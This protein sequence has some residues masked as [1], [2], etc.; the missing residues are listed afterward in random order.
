MM[1]LLLYSLNQLITMLKGIGEEK[2]DDN[3]TYEEILAG[4]DDLE[5]TLKENLE[6]ARS[7][8]GDGNN[9]PKG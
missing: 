9:K 8:Y 6:Y 2:M 7:H 5:K 1:K 4:L 3:K